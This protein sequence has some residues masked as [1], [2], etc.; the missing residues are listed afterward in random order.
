MASVAL[1]ARRLATRLPVAAPC[2]LR[3]GPRAPSAASQG[4]PQRRLQSSGSGGAVRGQEPTLGGPDEQL[5]AALLWSRFVQWSYRTFGSYLFPEKTDICNCGADFGI[6]IPRPELVKLEGIEQGSHEWRMQM[7]GAALYWHM[8]SVPG[9]KPKDADPDM[10]RGADVLEVGCMKGGGARYLSELTGPRR[11]LAT[12]SVQE[13]VDAC[14]KLHGSA[15]GLEFE[16]AD[17]LQLP[18][19][20]PRE[21]FDFVLCIQSV[22]AFGDPARFIRGVEHVLRPGGRL[23]LCDGLSRQT[24]ASLQS[25]MREVGLEQTVCTDMSRAVHAAGLCK[26]PHGTSYIRMVAQK[27]AQQQPDATAEEL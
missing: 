22:S 10:L 7:F 17:A 25:T 12:D 14:R 26:I 9:D 11:Y 13:H 19:T 8:A 15:P 16:R 4:T 27:Q 6:L 23:L 20:L 18:E 3:L 21:S 2:G 1:G 5:G 24:L